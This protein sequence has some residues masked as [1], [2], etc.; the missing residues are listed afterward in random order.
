LGTVR[1]Q[2]V[3]YLFRSTSFAPK[4]GV[5]ASQHLHR[6]IGQYV[7]QAVIAQSKRLDT[8]STGP[9]VANPEQADE[10]GE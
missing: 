8:N 7:I 3:D 2:P 10:L 9:S 5:R 6:L 1:L 4:I